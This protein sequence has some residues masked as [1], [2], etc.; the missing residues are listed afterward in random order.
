MKYRRLGSSGC[1]VSVLSLGSWLTFGSSVDDA[2]TERCVRAAVEAGINF[3]DTADIYAYGAAERSLGQALRPYR[4]QDYVLATKTFWPMSENVNDRGLSR[5]HL[6]EACEASLQRLHTDYVDLYQ[7]HRFD[8]DTPTEEVVRAMEDLIRQGKVLYWGVS[9]WT[10]AQIAEACAIADRVLG[11][12][13]ITNQPQ[14]NLLDRSIEPEIMP[15]AAQR[16]MGQIVFCPLAQGLLTGKYADGSVPSESRAADEQRGGFLRPK[17]TERN[18]AASRT[19][20]AEANQ[21]GITPAQLALAWILR[22]GEVTSA[23]VGATRPE[24]I[25]ENAKA[26][27]LELP[28]DVLARLD[29]LTAPGEKTA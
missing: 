10:A 27:D 2:G 4:R 3:F 22:R 25:T 26:A 5:K 19:L 6:M 28:Y 11:Y 1:K 20:V 14:Y 29:T 17:L 23:I 16:G 24:Q 12:R 18:L 21:L 13:P 8:P 9:V 15:A 7:C